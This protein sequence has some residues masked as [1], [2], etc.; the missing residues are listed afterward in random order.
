MSNGL[1]V[2]S[3]DLKAIRT[4][5]VGEYIYYTNSDKPE[6]F[7]NTIQNIDIRSNYDSRKVIKK[8]NDDFLIGLKNII[9]E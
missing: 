4:S 6:D 9:K 8:L 2:V 7:A 3:V 1:R 5:E